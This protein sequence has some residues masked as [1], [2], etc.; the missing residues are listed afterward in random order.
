[1]LVFFLS[2]RNCWSVL[3]LLL[4]GP[5]LPAQNDSTFVLHYFGTDKG[6]P[7]RI[8][9]GAV[10]D[11]NNLLWVG[12]ERG[13]A[14][15]DGHRVT[16][17]PEV[18]QRFSSALRQGPHGR[19]YAT[20]VKYPDSLEIFDPVTM[21]ASGL[22]LQDGEGSYIG[23]YQSPGRL[24]YFARGSDIYR[25]EVDMARTRVQGLAYE[26]RQGDRLVYADD[27]GYLIHRA[28][29]FRLEER[30]DGRTSHYQLPSRSPYRAIH[31]DAEGGI[32][33]G[34]MD[35]LYHKPVGASEFIRQAPFPSGLPVNFIREDSHHNILVG[36]LDPQHRKMW[37]L[38]LISQGVRTDALHMVA[39]DSRVLDIIGDNFNHRYLL[40]TYG[41]LYH[42]TLDERET[43]SPFRRYLYRPNLP[44][45]QFGHV[46]R[47]FTADDDGNVYVNKDS[48]D[49]FWFR[50]R[51]SDLSLDTLVLR[52][53][54]GSVSNTYG[55]GTNMINYQGD[56]YGHNCDFDAIDAD[57]GEFVGFVY[58]YRPKTEAMQRW[59]LP[60]K[61]YVIRWIDRGRRAG[62][63]FVVTQEKDVRSRGLLYYFYPASGAFRQIL[64]VG[65]EYYVEGNTKSAVFDSTR[66]VWWIATDSDFYRFDPDSEVLESFN[67][68]N[69]EPGGVS[70][71]ILEANGQLLLSTF[72]NGLHLFDPETASTHQ[73]GG[74]IYPGQIAP[75]PAK[76]LDLPTNDIAKI[77]RIASE[78]LIVT[79]FAGL[80]L[81]GNKDNAGF[82]FTTKEGLNH[83]EFNTHSLF[84]NPTDGRWY[85]GGINGFNSFL[86][87]ALE[88]KPS[89]YQ[90]VL[91]SIR[92][93]DADTPQETISPIAGNPDGPVDIP[94][95]NLYFGFDFAVP[96]FSG[97]GTRQYQTFLE[98]HD[99]SWT[100]VTETPSVRYTNLKPGHYTFH[101]RAYDTWKR[102]TE[103]LSFP[104][105]VRPPWY[106]SWWAITALATTLLVSVY[107]LYQ[108]RLRR[109]RRKLEVQ[110]RLQSLELRSLRQQLNPHFISNAM[111]AIRQFVKA[112]KP[113]TAAAYLTDFALVMRSFLEAS[114]NRFT[115]LKTEIDML[116]RYIRLEQL[117]FPGKF[118]YQIDVTQGIDV[119]MD[120]IPSLLL[121]P[122][123]ENAINHGFQPLTEGGI[124]TVTFASHAD[125]EDLMVCTIS[126]N[127]VGRKLA[128]A[129]ETAKEHISRASEILKDRL[130][131]FAAEDS[132]RVQITTTDLYPD[133]H[134]TGTSVRL[135]IERG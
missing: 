64:P 8:V 49:P 111:T 123:V 50:V 46:M 102:R 86:A 40:T 78:Q 89:P 112:E 84:R 33:I 103:D 81:H 73:A 98:G 109:A 34:N 101:L 134:H 119:E 60:E 80:V 1:M 12:S 61:D 79:T 88:P 32:W 87:E 29:D 92:T 125:D 28:D 21:R 39:D 27:R 127:G 62:E 26:A 118:D 13:L 5:T 83:D 126:D 7:S 104:V 68:P 116:H 52:D 17:F 77:A 90:A 72:Q 4:V 93:L 94:T 113:T 15:I 14:R 58:R 129:R 6:L 74:V 56:I 30:R 131:H 45:G 2:S 85:A 96:D 67:I 3:L 47:G 133:Q 25:L 55:C 48:R 44:E 121:Q 97:T 135:V 20:S 76:F 110:Q 69:D 59:P 43:K 95:S 75:D 66:L 10:F 128:A 124:L 115:P 99:P 54:D 106:Q 36:H 19:I 91:T 9:Y 41:G 23:S 107:A 42:Y 35:G 37:A 22:R 132:I 38:D 31:R 108:Y 53:N 18:M 71:I 16:T 63:L 11:D 57:R 24:R 120:V 122:L 82:I 117:R 51:A 114:R 70:D 100:P 130:E 65:P 105:I